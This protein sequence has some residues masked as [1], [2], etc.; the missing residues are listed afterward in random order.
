MGLSKGQARSHNTDILDFFNL[1][2][3]CVFSL[4]SPHR[5]DT[6]SFS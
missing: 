4:E 6:I 3:F 5:L 1:R 2:V